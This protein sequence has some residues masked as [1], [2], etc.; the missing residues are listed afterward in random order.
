MRTNSDGAGFMGPGLKATVSNRLASTAPA[1]LAQSTPL[2]SGASGHQQQ[3]EQL[4]QQQLNEASSMSSSSRPFISL[5]GAP[6]RHAAAAVVIPVQN[7]TSGT[8]SGGKGNFVEDEYK[9]SAAAHQPPPI[10]LQ[11]TKPVGRAG[12]GGGGSGVAAAPQRVQKPVG[13]GAGSATAAAGDEELTAQLQ[14][15]TIT[16]TTWTQRESALLSLNDLLLKRPPSPLQVER[17]VDAVSER[18]ADPHPRVA[19]ACMQVLHSLLQVAPIP[20]SPRIDILLPRVFARASEA[21]RAATGASGCPQEAAFAWLAAIRDVV[22]ADV[23]LPQLLR[24]IDAPQ[25]PL[26]GRLLVLDML[27]SSAMNHR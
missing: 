22:P 18:L 24:C 11:S 16:A 21:K 12:G 15:L 23:L 5:K 20:L 17:T 3:H 13:T 1:S 7:K 25:L 6:Q 10:S 2:I 14:I 27:S 4:Q 8:S 26:R 9:T 19:C